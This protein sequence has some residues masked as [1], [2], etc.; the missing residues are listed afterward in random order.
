MAIRITIFCGDSHEAWSPKNEATGI[1]GSEE[2]VINI[3]RELVKQKHE[4]V[5]FNR[6]EDDAG[7]YDGVKYVDFLDYAGEPTDVFVGWRSLMPWK[8]G[9]NYKVGYHWL[10]DTTP[11]EDVKQALALGASK[12]MVLSKWH[13][14]LYGSIENKWLYLTRNGV[15]MAQFD[16]KVERVPGRVF[17]GSSYDRGLKELLENW[18]KIKL[19][20]PHATLHIAYGWNT[21]ES[22][23]KKQGEDGYAAFKNVK[24]NLEQMMDQEG[25]THLGRISHEEVAREML[26]ADVW[27]YPTWW[28]E[29]SCITAIK[30][31]VAGAIPVVIPTAAVAETVQHGFKT[32][33]GYYN[34]IQGGVAMPEEA[35]EQWTQ[36]VIS[37]LKADEKAKA[38]LR[39]KM[40]AEAREVYDWE[41]IAKEW[42][43]EFEGAL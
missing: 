1:G 29:I 9:K 3:A 10:H 17:Y 26:E 27:G 31:Q 23:A 16:Q 35:M 2:A 18:P 22:I 21:W 25:I 4:V 38:P 42:L 6:C 33:R 12:V 32:D 28:P 34:S 13:R 15:N 40:M 41:T 11:E 5:V 37:L 14:R 36:A 7:T 8:M 20:V 39:K 19:A 43:V 24:E 30:A